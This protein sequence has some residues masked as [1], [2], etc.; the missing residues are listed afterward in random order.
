MGYAFGFSCF[1]GLNIEKMSMLIT[2][3]YDIDSTAPSMNVEMT[4][5]TANRTKR[6][7]I[8]ATFEE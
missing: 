2:K 7:A 4:N 8:M 5:K 6:I 1:L 3:V